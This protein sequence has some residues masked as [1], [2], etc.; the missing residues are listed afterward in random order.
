MRNMNKNEEITLKVTGMSS[1]GTGIA[2]TESGV[3]FVHGAL[4]GEKVSARIVARKRD[5]SVADTL[6]VIEPS[7]W[8]AEPQCRYY[9]RCGG[10]QLQHADYRLQLRL[11]AGIVKDAMIRLGGFSREKFEGLECEPSPEIWG[12]RNKAA[13]P[14]QEFK[15]HLATGF[16]RAGTHRLEFVR[17]C[18]VNAPKINEIY[19]KISW[20]FRKRTYP[21][22]GYDEKTQT[23]KLRHIILRAGINTDESLL[24]FVINGK[25]SDPAMKA[26]LSFARW[27]GPN[28]MTINRNSKPGNTILGTQTETMIGPGSISECI[29]GFRL[30]FG[31]GSFFQINTGQAEKLFEYAASM[32]EGA[33]N[34]LELYSGSGALTCFLAR[35][36]QSITS[37][38]EFKPA[39]KMAERNLKVNNF[40]NV[41]AFCG[42]SEEVIADLRDAYD[43]VVLDPP[44]DGC[45]RAVLEAI[46]EFRVRRVVYVS[47][48]PATL[49]RDCKILAGHGYRLE[50]IRAF[51]MFPQTAH[52][53]SV[54]VMVR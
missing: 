34:I 46:N 9:G 32:A 28:T 23:G 26:L 49:A 30:M 35:N 47:C 17:E 24:S 42:K 14:V 6:S 54:V 45:E 51:D 27:L 22:D 43:A 7:G 33:K 11:K 29:G 16:Y 1:E 40:V 20:S 31:T 50:S 3:F 53:E 25:L 21:F 37:I 52:V 41:H 5:Y 10:C 8:R 15:G 48:N 18:P 13:F 19:G 36:A 44:R 38:E 2:R 4:P 12:Y 39:V